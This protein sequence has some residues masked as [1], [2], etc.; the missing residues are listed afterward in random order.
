MW[1]LKKRKAMV[2]DSSTPH[3]ISDTLASKVAG[4][5]LG[6]Q[7]KFASVMNKKCSNLN[8][9]KL[10]ALLLFFSLLA[11]G[12]SIYLTIDAVA[13]KQ[14]DQKGFTVIQIDVPKHFDKTGGEVMT[15]NYV[16]EETI[17]KIESFRQYLDSL[18]QN[19][20]KQYDSIL[21]ALPHLMDSLEV[22]E[23]LYY[24][25]KQK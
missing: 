23:K 10:K 19:R 5:C 4:T 13:G 1:F 15:D 11:G 21:Q 18:K 25:Q 16:D 12:Y 14:K 7:R 24:S 6:A 17:Y 20:R 8:S 2:K 9:R 3:S 22:L